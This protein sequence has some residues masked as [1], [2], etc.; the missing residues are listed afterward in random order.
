MNI[1]TTLKEAMAI[2]G[3]VGVALVDYESGMSLGTLGGG[4]HL[5][6]EVAAAGNTEVLRAKQRTLKSIDMDDEIED[7]LITLGHQY[8]LI[9]PLVS[10][11]GS[12]FLY[13]A[14]DRTR[15]NLALARHSLKRLEAGLEV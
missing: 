7:I 10:T 2:E 13:L 14:L 6:L 11:S 4:P 9:R 3:A 8:H 5:D 15:S 12:L 1:E